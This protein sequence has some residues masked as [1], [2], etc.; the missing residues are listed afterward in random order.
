MGNSQPKQTLAEIARENK[1]T[2]DRA[3]RHI[4][5]ERTKIQNQEPKLLREIKQM[6]TKN[7]HV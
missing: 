7:Q 3:V 6:A 4:E 2:V 1:K 5:R